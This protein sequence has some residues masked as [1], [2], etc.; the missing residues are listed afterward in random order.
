MPVGI[1]AWQ[2]KR[3]LHGAPNCN[4]A[5]FVGRSRGTGSG[6]FK[7]HWP[8]PVVYPRGAAL[9]MRVYV[10]RAVRQIDERYG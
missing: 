4:A 1:P 2:A 6:L 7:W 8:E 9:M 10:I 5:E 3:L